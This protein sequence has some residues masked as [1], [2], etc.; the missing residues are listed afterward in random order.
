MTRI[1]EAVKLQKRDWAI[2]LLLLT[3]IATNFVWY[4][5]SRTQELSQ[6]SDSQSWLRQQIQINKLKA[7]IDNGTKPC[8]ITLQQ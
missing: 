7:C 6:K 4:Q 3:I 1:K 5:Y 2:V 8:D